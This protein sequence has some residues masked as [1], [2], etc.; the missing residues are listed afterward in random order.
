[1]S[2]YD[3]ERLRHELRAAPAPELPD[4]LADAAV[5]ESGRRRRT[6]IAGGAAGVAVVAAAAV[7]TSSWWLPGGTGPATVATPSPTASA[8]ATGTAPPSV[9]PTPSVAPSPSGTPSARP[10]STP[11]G[12]PSGSP[13]GDAPTGSVPADRMID[14]TGVGD[15]R[16]GMSLAEGMAA[17]LA[18]DDA[19]V[20]SPYEASEEGARRYPATWQYW[21]ED[22]L[23]A[24][25]VV[26]DPDRPDAEAAS[27]Y[28]ATGGVRIGD[29]YADVLLAF[30]PDVS[31]I[32]LGR[33]D[34]G[35]LAEG[36]LPHQ[37]MEGR[38]LMVG[39]RDRAIVFI[40]GPSDRVDYIL[41]TT[42]D[43]EAHLRPLPSC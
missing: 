4:D 23:Q 30:E 19:E 21:T 17:G 38:A 39:E 15:L 37:G 35:E 41:V 3:P 32:G 13:G 34:W 42:L 43:V 9:P 6:R 36:S 25:A 29:A 2:P 27:E 16:V 10:T 12:T 26:G 40:F 8:T 7:F 31:A 22:G 20:C 11:S 14:L 24:F 1:M 5:H 33:E 28:V 18:I